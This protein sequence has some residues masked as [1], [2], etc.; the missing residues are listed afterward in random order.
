MSEIGDI[1]GRYHEALE[2]SLQDF[3]RER[4]SA[5]AALEGLYQPVFSRLIRNYD[6]IRD[7]ASPQWVR[8]LHNLR[9]RYGA[10]E[11]SLQFAAIDG[12]C[13]KELLSEMLVFYGGSFG[14]TTSTDPPRRSLTRR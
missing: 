1:Y 14:S 13:G 8:T 7:R 3:A 2:N 12:T 4:Q 11:R 10:T 6:W 9:D 5:F